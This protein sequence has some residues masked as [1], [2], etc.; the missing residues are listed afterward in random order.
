MIHRYDAVD[1]EV[2]WDTVEKN[3]I[4]LINAIEPHVPP[5]ETGEGQ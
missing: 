5:H 3:L 4:S 1:L 2:V